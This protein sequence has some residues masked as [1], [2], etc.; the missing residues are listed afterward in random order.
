MMMNWIFLRYETPLQAEKALCQ[1]GTLFTLPATS[2]IGRSPKMMLG[3]LR[4]DASLANLLGLN[5]KKMWDSNAV[6][7]VVGEKKTT[8]TLF[9]KEE[10]I[11]LDKQPPTRTNTDTL[12]HR[13]NICQKVMSWFLGLIMLEEDGKAD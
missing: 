13:T 8:T 4:V 2:S 9:T 7:W 6:P 11:L 3:V 12:Q 5:P 1:N 10:D